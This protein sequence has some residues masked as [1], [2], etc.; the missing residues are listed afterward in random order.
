MRQK[1]RQ[2]KY[3]A[4]F[5]LLIIFYFS[6]YIGKIFG[7]VIFPDEFGYWFYAAKVAGYDWSHI[8]SLGSYYS[9]G[10][11]LILTPIFLLFT[12]AVVAYRVAVAVNFILLAGSGYLLIRLLQR[13][14]ANEMNTQKMVLFALLGILYPSNLVYAKTT[15]TETL[16]MAAFVTVCYVF[17]QY[18]ST[19]KISLLIATIIL[20]AYMYMVHMRSLAVI[21][22]ILL[23]LLARTVR[24]SGRGRNL[25]ITGAITAVLFLAAYFIRAQ[26][27]D[28][29]FDAAD[30]ILLNANGMKGQIPKIMSMFH[31]K[32]VID[33]L[34][35]LAGKLLYMGLA[36]F[37][38]A[39]FGVC[40]NISRLI[41]LWKQREQKDSFFYLFLLVV[42]IG[43]IG[44]TTIYN[45]HPSRVDGVIYG[46]YHEYIFP[47]LIAL[48]VER[49]Q[50]MKH[51][52]RNT[53]MLSATQMLFLLSSIQYVSNHQLTG[54]EGCFALGMSYISNI[55]EMESASF[56]VKAYIYG[57]T[58]TVFILFTIR[59][60]EKTQIQHCFIGMLII[61]E[62]I[63]SIR[64][65]SLYTDY[66][67]RDAQE[68][69]I[70]TEKLEELQNS[71]NRRIVYIDSYE[72]PIIGSIQFQLRDA[73]IHILD[74]REQI[75]DYTDEELQ[76]TD[77]VLTATTEEL[78]DKLMEKY[79]Q[80]TKYGHFTL[81]YNE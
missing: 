11:S 10:Y 68:D 42:T 74:E 63:L 66:Y 24:K 27:L 61:L 76:T 4:I 75:S 5:I 6:F 45:I 17:Y 19:E 7:F 80:S 23:T 52:V 58:L 69:M 81:L 31:I 43:Q 72:L 37:G 64:T 29:E 3:F 14:S 33:F 46:R 9:F 47:I 16:L 35:S 20:A 22:A 50:R 79:G 39:C 73:E 38:L 28:S 8:V 25:L 71:S 59:I 70:L 62:I 15:L 77:L 26:I 54:Y 48:G 78:Q 1:I 44:I 36:T 30:E 49:L 41:R 65:S 34:Q 32:G 53:V 67:N 13:L 56:L 21:I 2:N 51:P 60:S 40:E 55:S 18:L 12:D 57:I